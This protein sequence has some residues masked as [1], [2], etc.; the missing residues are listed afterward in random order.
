M[1]DIPAL[2][3]N[4]PPLSSYYFYLTEGCNLACQH[5]WLAPAFQH[6]GGTGGHLSFDLFKVAIDEGVPLGLTHAKLTG[7][8]PTLHPDFVQLVE[9]AKERG[10][11]VSLETNG[12]RL[13]SD[14]A[15]YLADSQVVSLSISLDGSKAETHDKFRGVKGSFE[16]A[17]QG[18]RY[19]VEAGVRPQII[20][21]VH[22]GNVGEI[23]DLVNLATR[24]EASSVKFNL[25]QPSG[26]GKVMSERGQVLEIE[27]LIELGK[28]VEKDLQ[29]RAPFR[30]YYSWPI[31]FFTLGRLNTFS[32]YTCNVQHI[33]GILPTG[34]MALCGIGTQVPEL[35]FG[36]LGVDRVA[37]VWTT[38]PTLLAIRQDIP[39]R[40]EG[41]CG[42]CVFRD[43]CKGL[44]IAENFVT[45]KRITSPNWFCEMAEQAD[46]FPS[47]KRVSSQVGA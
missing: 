31:A 29:K 1:S 19:L 5:C 8:E 25:I 11:A 46:L 34:H 36:Q 13:T 10:V 16:A 9:Y 28:W 30:L 4:C 37:D 14:L 12:T 32:G 41:V 24:L 35:C 45:G 38:H 39:T 27:Q 22:P 3:E 17:C 15:R 47:S 42:D 6:N 23:E 43:F 21:S 7:G 40:L 33:L 20:M 26:R 2:P 18:I 44:C